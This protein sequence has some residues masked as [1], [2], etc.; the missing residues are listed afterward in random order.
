MSHERHKLPTDLTPPAQLPWVR[1]L[2]ARLLGRGLSRLQAQHRDSWFQ[3]HANGQRTGHADGLREGYEEGRVDGYEA[4]RQVLVIRDTRPD[5]HGVPGLDDALFDDWRHDPNVTTQGA[6]SIT[7]SARSKIPAVIDGE[8]ML[9][10]REA[11]VT[12]QPRA[13]RALAP[14]PPAG[15]DSL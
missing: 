14:R 10:G 3:G 1:R 9:L 2:A 8:P 13:F 4:G 7:V 11:A 12:F 6:R 5:A 15:E